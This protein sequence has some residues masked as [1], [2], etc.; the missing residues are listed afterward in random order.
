MAKDKN[1]HKKTIL[2]VVPA[3]ISGGV[4]R[5]TLEI[6]KKIVDSGNNSIVISAGGPLVKLLEKHGSK[7]IIMN[8]ASKNPII[9]WCNAKKITAI[10]R[11]LDVDIIHARSRAP[12]WSCY[13]SAKSTGIKL[14]T[15]FHGI[16][17]F[18]SR[19]KKFY[20]SVMTEGHK[21]IA[22]SNFVKE[23]II[24]NYNIDKSKIRVIHRG[25]NH[26]DFSKS[27][28]STKLITDFRE[29]YKVPINIPV[30]L[31]PAR[32]TEW[33]G[34]II[35]IEALKKI[36][37]LNFYCIMAGDL[38]KHPAYVMR[39]KDKIHQYKLQNRIQLFGNEPNMLGLYGISDIVLSTSIEPEAF[40]RTIIEAQSMEKIVIATNIGGACETIE[41]GVTG[42]HVPPKDS[43]ALAERIAHCLSIIGSQESIDIT[44]RAKKVTTDKF[45][46]D[47]MLQNTL[48]V[49]DDAN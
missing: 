1:Y 17:N 16:Y 42:F 46:L 39:I 21:V 7:H 40:G 9:I 43:D 14:I 29:K 27:K 12:A 10:I 2:Q 37:D 4:E 24:D 31:L 41:D 8:V 45:S 47:L 49:Y 15:T 25:V 11:K 35:L 26:H 23:H 20:N 48:S 22:V 3:L 28:L 30:L 18:K 34:H 19:I 36:K 44:S 6:A 32:M 13:I 33:K 5:G 38:A